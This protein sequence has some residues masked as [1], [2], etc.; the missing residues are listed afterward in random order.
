MFGVIVL[1]G[2]LAGCR[3]EVATVVHVRPADTRLDLRVELTGDA[4]A[5]FTDDDV[6]RLVRL[7]ARR[8]GQVPAVD[9]TDTTLTVRT[10]VP[11]ERVADLAPFTGVAGVVRHDRTVTVTLVEPERLVQAVTQSVADQPDA[12]V[13][14]PTLLANSRVVIEV[15]FDGGVSDV[16][17]DPVPEVDGARARLVR[18]LDDPATGTFAVTGDP[19]APL[20]ER[21]PVVPAAAAAA[22]VAA[23]LVTWRLVR[24]RP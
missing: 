20:T 17:G 1:C 19:T 22:L 13:L 10:P 23:A 4:A 18:S 3:A 11:P 12:A 15:V 9:R 14:A 21:W 2:V 7:V 16:T 6:D 8:T 24:R 5:A